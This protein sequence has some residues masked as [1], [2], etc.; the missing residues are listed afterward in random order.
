MFGLELSP[1]NAEINIFSL[2]F[3]ISSGMF[4][5]EN[6]TKPLLCPPKSS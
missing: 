5:Q 1:K 2:P 6:P 3:F 4:S